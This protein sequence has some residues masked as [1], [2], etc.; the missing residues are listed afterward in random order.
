MTFQLGPKGI[1]Y[2][3]GAETGGYR[4]GSGRM[5]LLA[6][7]EP[8][9]SAYADDVG[10]WTIGWGHT[11][12]VRPGQMISRDG[13]E[14]AFAADI[15]GSV[16]AVNAGIGSAATTQ[17]QFD[18]MV[19]LAFNIGAGNFARSTV[20]RNHHAGNKGAAAGA[21]ALFNKGHVHGVLV[22]LAG[23]TKRRADEAAIYLG[24]AA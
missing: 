5:H 22:T 6:H 8:A 12:G 2:L 24:R 11:K 3:K 18:A 20:L 1:K 4:D 7:G 15:A 10:V 23:L 9:L 21:F 17:D 13:A 16:A 14:A 19:I